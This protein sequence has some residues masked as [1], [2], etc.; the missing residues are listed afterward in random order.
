MG[1][2]AA[3]NDDRLETYADAPVEGLPAAVIDP[4]MTCFGTK[5]ITTG[6]VYNTELVETPPTPGWT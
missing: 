5:L 6:I 3:E 1:D 2:D 4:D